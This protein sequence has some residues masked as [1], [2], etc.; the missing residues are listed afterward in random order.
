MDAEIKVPSA[1]NP[2]LLNSLFLK[3]V[4]S[5]NVAFHASPTA[6]NIICLSNFYLLDACFTYTS[7]SC[8]NSS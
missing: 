8:Q 6:G 7:L 4:V 5:Q 3:P 2:K 1:E